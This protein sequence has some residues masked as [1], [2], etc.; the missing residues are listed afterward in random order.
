MLELGGSDPFVVL[1]D[2]DVKLSC[3]EAVKG[4]M[5]NGGQSCIAAKRFIVTTKNEKE[6]TKLLKESTQKLEV[7]DPMESSTNIGPL[8]RREQVLR[9]HQQVTKSVREGAKLL[10]GGKIPSRKGFYYEP[11]ILTNCNSKMTCVREEVF[12]PVFSVIPVKDDA[13]AITEAN[14]S[15]FG[16][17]ASIWTRDEKRGEEIAK[18]K[19]E[20]GL[21]Y[22]N[23]VVKSDP[24]LPFGGVKL[25][26]IGREL[27]RY[28]ILEFANIK[29]VIVK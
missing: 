9:V 28:G 21:I 15:Q 10:L 5:V 2:A 29:S 4:R 13:A 19:I 25:S 8:V 1:S 23:G 16:L 24:R 6:F 14:N 17:G 20:A 26:G 11:T 7:G 18:K 27:S 3:G 12:G 22:V